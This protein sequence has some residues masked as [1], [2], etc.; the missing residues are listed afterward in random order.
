MERTVLMKARRWL[1]P[2]VAFLLGIGV[3]IAFAGVAVFLDLRVLP[4]ER[5]VAELRADLQDL[6]ME[7]PS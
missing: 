6:P 1:I 3:T 4:E 7:K 5:L 2:V